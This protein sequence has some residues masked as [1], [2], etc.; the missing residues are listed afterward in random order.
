[1]KR[2]FVCKSQNSMNRN[3]LMMTLIL[4]LGVLGCTSPKGYRVQGVIDGIQ[5]GKACLVTYDGK[6]CDTL[7]SAEIKN[8]KFE[9]SGSVTG[10]TMVSL[11]VV[12]IP[13]R[14][15]VYLENE[16]YTVKLNPN[17]LEL[18]QIEGGGES[19]KLA[20]EYS[21]ID[22][23]LSKVI[24]GI[25]DEYI[26]A[27]REPESE[28]FLRLNN[29]LDS[30]QR[31][32]ES[33]KQT[34]LE[35]H[36]NSYFALNH[37]A[38]D[39]SRLSLDELQR[40]FNLL[41]EE[42]QATALGKQVREQIQKMESLSVGQV[43]PDFTVQTPEGKSFTMYSVKAKLKIIDFWAS[44]CAPCR[45]LTP[46]LIKLYEEFHSQGF[47]I[48]GISMDE[49]KDAWVKAIGEEKMSW[50][51]GSKLDG[52]KPGNPLNQLYN[53][54]NGIPFFVLVDENNQILATSNQVEPLR[55]IVEKVLKK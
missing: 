28:R 14:A 48:V 1:M 19:Q 44:W 23:A 32:A 38:V 22:I 49:N 47:E 5:E 40:R 55:K 2:V 45:A 4:G 39:A 54:T 9:M 16:D 29:F 21:A 43:A 15:S 53:I 51:Q 33:R 36:A 11:Q 35:Q 12:D 3:N 6:K 34:F 18:S 42:L 31:D 25:R 13:T 50:I 41:S 37:L 7:S 46:Q 10:L 20:N 52:F 30:V 26:E 8:G 24:D 17:N 27:V